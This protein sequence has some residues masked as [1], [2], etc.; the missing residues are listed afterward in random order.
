MDGYVGTFCVA[1]TKIPNLKAQ[2]NNIDCA[3]SW[4]LEPL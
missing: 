1:H 2:V 4:H 3:N